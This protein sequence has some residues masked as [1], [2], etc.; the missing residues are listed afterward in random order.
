MN[1][2]KIDLCRKLIASTEGKMASITF[3][4][5]DGSIRNM[6]CRI[7][8]MKGLKENPRICKNGTSNTTAHLNHIL[9]V[10]DMKISGYR[11]IN[12]S[13]LTHFKCGEIDIDFA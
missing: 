2:S 9:T 11:N 7:G 6:V 12:L 3:V 8:V 13:T 10:Y 4:K 1:I 5:K